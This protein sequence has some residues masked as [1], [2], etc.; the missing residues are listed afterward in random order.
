MQNDR[1][2]C[3]LELRSLDEM[4][5]KEAEWLIADYMPRYQITSFAGD[6]GS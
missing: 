1:N 6:G 5:E 2:N 4:E 3:C